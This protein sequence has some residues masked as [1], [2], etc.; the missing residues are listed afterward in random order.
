M[1]EKGSVNS[2]MDVS[3]KD[4]PPDLGAWTGEQLPRHAADAVMKIESC[5]DE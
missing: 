3:P 5:N 1:T 2:P 4:I